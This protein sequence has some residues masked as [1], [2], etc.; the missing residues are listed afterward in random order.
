[1]LSLRVVAFLTFVGWATLFSG[2]PVQAADVGK[3]TIDATIPNLRNDHGQVMCTLFNTPDGF[4]EHSK[5][6][7][8]IA[9]PIQDT[10]A[11]CRF[12][13]VTYGTYAIVSFHD[14]NHDGEFNQNWLGMP[15]EGFG[16]SDNPSALK[17]PSFDDAKFTVAKPEVAIDIKMNYWF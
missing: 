15:Q 2:T 8:T 6:A 13:H 10:H 11:T 7:V 12:E 9:V 3:A 16:F 5:H 4:P 1:M 17:K 14:E